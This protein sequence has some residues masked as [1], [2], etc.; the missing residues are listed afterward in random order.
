ML[1]GAG[2]FPSERLNTHAFKTLVPSQSNG[3]Y[4]I[5]EGKW[6]KEGVVGMYSGKHTH[7]NTQKTHITPTLPPAS[8]ADTRF[9]H[10]HPPTHTGMLSANPAVCAHTNT[11]RGNTPVLF[12]WTWIFLIIQEDISTMSATTF[13][14]FSHIFVLQ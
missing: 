3:E 11:H 1:P 9:T 6:G 10:T 14:L 8:F 2:N 13:L 5:K 12:P 7:K 4:A